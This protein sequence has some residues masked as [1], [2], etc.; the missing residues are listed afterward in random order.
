M[1][2]VGD[3]DDLGTPRPDVRDLTEDSARIHDRLVQLDPVVAALVDDQALA[4]HSGIH[5]DNFSHHRLLDERRQCRVQS[6]QLGVFLFQRLLPQHGQLQLLHLGTQ[7]GVLRAQRAACRE[8]VGHPVPRRQW[9][10]YRNLH[11]VRGGLEPIADALGPLRALIQVHQRQGKDGVDGET[12]TGRGA[13]AIDGP[14]DACAEA[15]HFTP[16]RSDRGPVDP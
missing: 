14:T 12:Q 8:A 5:A 2:R 4:Q 3:Q 6:A 16:V 9:R 11:R 7:L 13:T 15:G 1:F 10:I